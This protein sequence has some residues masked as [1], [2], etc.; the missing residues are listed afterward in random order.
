MMEH[1]GQ[2]RCPAHGQSAT[3]AQQCPRPAG[4]LL[5]RRVPAGHRPVGQR[6]RPGSGVTSLSGL[7][8]LQAGPVAPPGDGHHRVWIL[9]HR[10]RL[11]AEAAL[12]RRGTLLGF[13]AH[14]STSSRR[15]GAGRNVV[16]WIM[17]ACSVIASPFPRLL[18]AAT[19]LRR[20]SR[21]CGW[22]SGPSCADRCSRD[23]G[24][25]PNPVPQRG[26]HGSLSA[27]R[28]TAQPQGRHR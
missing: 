18:A 2:R 15:P 26:S 5:H 11:C 7:E 14:A 12:S 28:V 22:L 8:R 24:Y 3:I 27:R 16:T 13:G 19:R 4:A 25:E 20:F 10:A 9:I 1:P 17:L 6:H 21:A 23:D